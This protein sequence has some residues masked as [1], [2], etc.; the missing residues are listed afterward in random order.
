M[1]NRVNVE[2][3]LFNCLT[4]YKHKALHFTTY[5]RMPGDS[6]AYVFHTLCKISSFFSSALPLGHQDVTTEQ[7]LITIADIWP[8][9]FCVRLCFCC[10]LYHSDT[11]IDSKIGR[12]STHIWCLA[13]EK[14]DYSVHPIDTKGTRCLWLNSSSYFLPL[15]AS[16]VLRPAT[17][18]VTGICVCARVFQ[19]NR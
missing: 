17:T 1:T 6:Q 4:A 12:Q 14:H 13:H 18:T 2:I 9:S 3:S 5:C 11:Y 8:T 15:S 7:I 10:Q 16:T 19:Q